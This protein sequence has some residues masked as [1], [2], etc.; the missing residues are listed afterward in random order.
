MTT[1]AP[2]IEAME[3]PPCRCA[4]YSGVSCEGCRLLNEME[5]AFDH[6][7]CRYADLHPTEA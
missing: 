2:W 6:D 1:T 5:R 7:Q 3:L 4:P